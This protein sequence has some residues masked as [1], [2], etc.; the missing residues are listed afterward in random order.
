MEV[1]VGK[2]SSKKVI[3]KIPQY[4]Q[5]DTLNVFKKGC[6]KVLY[7][8]EAPTQVFCEYCKFLRTAFVIEH[9]WLLST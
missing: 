8:K 2:C 3:L 4:S 6:F 1:A 9:R 7:K 5:E